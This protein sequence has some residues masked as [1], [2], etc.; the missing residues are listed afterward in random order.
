MNVMQLKLVNEAGLEA[1]PAP[2]HE[3]QRSGNALSSAVAHSLTVEW[4]MSR[5]G[6]F[7]NFCR[8]RG[9]RRLL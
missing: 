9:H 6:R 3:R 1:I 7:G 5:L 4:A 2:H 8:C